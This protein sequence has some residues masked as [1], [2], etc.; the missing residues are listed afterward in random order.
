MES[1]KKVYIRKKRL[2]ESQGMDP[3]ISRKA[4]ALSE[5]I[6]ADAKAEAESV[7]RKYGEG[8][9][10]LKKEFFNKYRRQ[11]EI[12][13]HVNRPGEKVPFEYKV[14]VTASYFMGDTYN[15]MMRNSRGICS[16]EG[17]NNPGN[18]MSGKSR[19]AF[20]IYLNLAYVVRKEMPETLSHELMHT[21]SDIR[22]MRGKGDALHH[23]LDT[24]VSADSGYSEFNLMKYYFS[25]QEMRSNIQGVYSEAYTAVTRYIKD[26]NKAPDIEDFKEILKGMGVWRHLNSRVYDTEDIKRDLDKAEEYGRNGYGRG[27]TKL[28]L[29]KDDE[30]QRFLDSLENKAEFRKMTG[31]S[32]VADF[33]K[34]FVKK[35]KEFKLKLVK[36]AYKGYADAIK[37]YRK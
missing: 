26:N 6:Y 27:F 18:F 15:E 19:Y 33:R 3:E 7:K 37:E 29:L 5:K 35:G 11:Y 30:I 32:T 31:I 20:D 13:L 14:L 12:T 28:S 9:D 16:D 22:E 17:D 1:R 8:D 4:N 36:A 25:P 21:K 10:I 24:F 2:N 23:A 34:Y